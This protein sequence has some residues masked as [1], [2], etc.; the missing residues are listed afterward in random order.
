MGFRQQAVSG[1]RCI[2]V[3]PQLVFRHPLVRSAAYRSASVAERREVHGALAA[4]TDPQLD[5]ERRAWH[6]A[7]A[8]LSAHG[9]GSAFRPGSPV[10]G[11]H[12][13]GGG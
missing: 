9:P 8:V 12:L 2:T 6:R 3:L 1:I 11:I 5:P 7:Q 13:T 4:V 10:R